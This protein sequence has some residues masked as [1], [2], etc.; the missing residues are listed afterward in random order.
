MARTDRLEKTNMKKV[1]DEGNSLYTFYSVSLDG[2]GNYMPINS[3]TPEENESWKPFK[4]KGE[5]VTFPT[6]G[7]ALE[8]NQSKVN[9]NKYRFY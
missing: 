9:K 5:I 8:Y 4:S 6:L 2:Q 1:R 7:Q 3:K